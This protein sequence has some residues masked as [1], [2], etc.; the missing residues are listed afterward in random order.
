[1]VSMQST[2][3]CTKGLRERAPAH[4]VEADVEIQHGRHGLARGRGV[5]ARVARRRGERLEERADDEEQDAHAHAGDEEGELASEGVNQEKHEE[6]GSDDLHDAVY[7]GGKE[8]IRRA[9]VPNLAPASVG[10]EQSFRREETYRGE[11]LRR[12]VPDRVLS[13]PLLEEEYHD[14]DDEPYEVALAQE[15][16][17]RA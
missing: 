11:D 13:T 2:H 12:V 15:S 10:T 17:L 16:L 1:M 14:G 9:R 8:R 4:R 6:R 3:R 7:T 5:C